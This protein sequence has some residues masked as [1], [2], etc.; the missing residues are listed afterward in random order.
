MTQVHGP[1]HGCFSRDGADAEY[2]GH[3]RKQVLGCISEPAR[4]HG[5]E[6]SQHNSSPS[7]AGLTGGM[8][9]F[10]GLLPDRTLVE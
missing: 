6:N 10:V 4:P 5:L 7:I 8:F 9:R 2:S 3:H 1:A